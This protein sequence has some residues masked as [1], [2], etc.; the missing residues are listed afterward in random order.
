MSSVISICIGGAG[1]N[2]GKSCL[3]LNAEEHGIGADGFL[4]DEENYDASTINNNVLFRE[5][6]W[7]RWAP[8]SIFI[9]LEPDNIDQLLTS[10]IGQCL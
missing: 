2:I 4:I 3:E 9:D 8:R 5:N 7:G 1:V 6:S 10:D